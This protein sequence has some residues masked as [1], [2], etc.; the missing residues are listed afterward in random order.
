MSINYIIASSTGNLST[1]ERFD[2][3][4][5][6]ILQYHLQFLEKFLPFSKHIGQITICRQDTEQDGSVYYNIDEMV[7]KIQKLGVKVEVLPVD[8][9]GIS[10]YQYLCA[11]KAFPNFDYYVIMEDDWAINLAYIQNWDTYLLDQYKKAF[12]D[13][14]GFFNAW[15]PNTGPY[16]GPNGGY[17]MWDFH[18]AISTGML[19]RETLERYV[20]RCTIFV[21]QYEF[22][23]EL[24]KAN[25]AI[26]DFQQLG[27]PMRCFFF[28]TDPGEVEEFYEEKNIVPCFFVP[29][30]YLYSTYAYKKRFPP[31]FIHQGT[32]IVGFE[33]RKQVPTQT[34]YN[35][36]GIIDV[37]LLIKT[38]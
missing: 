20:A 31:T 15:S 4:A 23:K 1:R 33:E 11:Y 24:L 35:P 37:S 25:I 19:S 28:R 34:V 22:A 10:Y 17:L 6:Y 27:I 16:S 29:I 18:S 13:N 8:R 30:Q 36:D 38:K 14:I 7:R 2:K 32:R 21:G 3:T 26:K 12:S 9:Q 5:P